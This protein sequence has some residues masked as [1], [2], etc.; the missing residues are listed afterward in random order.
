MIN[1]KIEFSSDQ[2]NWI[3]HRLG[4]GRH[5]DAAEYVRD[6]IRDDMAAIDRF[7]D[8]GNSTLEAL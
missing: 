6:L 5:V 1:I 8:A 3:E 7:G 2:W 4:E